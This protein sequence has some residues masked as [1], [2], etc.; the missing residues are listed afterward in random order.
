MNKDELGVIRMLSERLVSPKE[1]SVDD[2][3][4]EDDDEGGCAS[5][6]E[7]ELVVVCKGSLAVAHDDAV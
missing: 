1:A 7:E 2:E 5:D 6:S 4:E 3:D